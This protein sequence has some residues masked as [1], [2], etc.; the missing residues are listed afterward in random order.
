[1]NQ[2]EL[3]QKIKM[4][5]YLLYQNKE[6]EAIQQ[7]Q[8]LLFIFQNMIQQQTR[9]QMELSGNFAL[10]MQQELLENFQNADM[11]G[12]ADCLKEKAL[13]FTEFYFQTRNR[14]KNE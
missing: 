13:L 3:Q 12:M 4:T 14:E 2:T 8:E 6:Q 7:V 9:E 1:M 10:I 5:Y 11:L